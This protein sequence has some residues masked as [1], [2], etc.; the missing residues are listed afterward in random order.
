MSTRPSA[1]WACSMKF[2]ASASLRR[3]AGM[4]TILRLVCLAISSAVCFERLLAAGADRDVD[5]FLRQCERD[6]FADALAA[7]GHQRG[8]AFELEG[9]SR[10]PL[11]SVLD[12]EVLDV[13]QV[14]VNRGVRFSA[15]ARAAFGIVVAGVGRA[16]AVRP[17]PTQQESPMR[18][19]RIAALAALMVSGALAA[20]PR[21]PFRG[22]AIMSAAGA[23]VDICRARRRGVPASAGRCKATHASHRCRTRAGIA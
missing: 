22:D 12:F 3:S 23:S 15:N 11:Q 18:W 14:P 1:L 19:P 13:D 2:L 17:P 7:A 9:P 10:S 4:A 8:L 20:D 6:A 16:T 5:A 21:A